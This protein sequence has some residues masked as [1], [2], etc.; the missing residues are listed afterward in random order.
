[1][2][3]LKFVLIKILFVIHCLAIYTTYC[4]L[5]IVD[6]LPEKAM[7]SMSKEGVIQRE[8]S[9]LIAVAF[10]CQAII[11]LL[12]LFFL[13]QRLRKLNLNKIAC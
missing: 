12:V 10:L 3:K 5:E 2:I 7:T 1:M 11:I 8:M 13:I 6:F 9:L 4:Y